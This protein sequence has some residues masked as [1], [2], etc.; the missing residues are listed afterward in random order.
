MGNPPL[1]LHFVCA[2]PIMQLMNGK[3]HFCSKLYVVFVP[4]IWKGQ[5]ERV[6]FCCNTKTPV[7]NQRGSVRKN[8]L[9]LSPDYWA[10]W[11]SNRCSVICWS[12][13]VH[14]WCLSRRRCFD[15]GSCRKGAQ[16]RTSPTETG[17]WKKVDRNMDTK[18]R[19][20]CAQAC[21]RSLEQVFHSGDRVQ[22][23][24]T[25]LNRRLCLLLRHVYHY[26]SRCTCSWQHKFIHLFK[27]C[28]RAI[29]PGKKNVPQCCRLSRFGPCCLH[30]EFADWQLTEV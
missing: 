11:W 10:A 7:N 19:F 26:P 13:V 28:L 30:T 6:V 1:L 25:Q 5:R 23:H 21:V 3:W 16:F 2:L 15:Q 27:S 9:P 24:C 20:K 29:E 4:I 17:K 22:C 14:M 18:R 12:P 8:F